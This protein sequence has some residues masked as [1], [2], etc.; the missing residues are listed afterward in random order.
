MVRYGVSVAGSHSDLF[1]ASLIAV[2]Y[3]ISCNI[4]PRYNGNQ[5][6]LQIHP[7]P[8]NLAVTAYICF[9]VFGH[10]GINTP[11]G[12]AIKIIMTWAQLVGYFILKQLYTYIL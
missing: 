12:G 1:S 6:Y 7:P 9:N 4:E 2:T 3:A 8:T 5:L 10:K 11:K